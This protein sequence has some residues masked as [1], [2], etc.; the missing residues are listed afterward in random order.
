MATKEITQEAQVTFAEAGACPAFVELYAELRE[1]LDPEHIARVTRLVKLAEQAVHD[2][3]YGAT[4]ALIDGTARHFGGLAPAIRAVAEHIFTAAQ[5]KDCGIVGLA[6][7]PDAPPDGAWV[8][9][10]GPS[11]PVRSAS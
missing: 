8:A 4:W 9:C 1:T 6:L 3:E 10:L 7:L 11:T 2:Y 5:P